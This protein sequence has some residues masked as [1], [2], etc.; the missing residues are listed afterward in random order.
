MQYDS[1]TKKSYAKS[2]SSFLAS[3]LSLHDTVKPL[4]SFL[5]FRI[6]HKSVPQ[7]LYDYLILTIISFSLSSFSAFCRKSRE[8]HS[9]R[10]GL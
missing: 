8:F 6:I 9:L 2:S 3:N 4:S 1:R 5:I 7:F 10:Y